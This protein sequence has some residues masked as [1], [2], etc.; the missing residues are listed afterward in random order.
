MIERLLKHDRAVTA[1]ALVVLCCLAWAW[2]LTGAGL[3][4]STGEMM[5]AALFPHQDATMR[6]PGMEMP[7]GQGWSLARSAIVVAMWWT[8]MIAMMIPGAA[9]T[10]LLYARVHGHAAG[11]AAPRRGLAPTGAFVAGYLLIWLAFSAAAAGAQWLLERQGVLSTETLSSN[12]RFLSAATLILAGLYQLS[13]LKQACLSHCRA[14]GSFLARHWRPGVA[15]AVRLGALHGAF[16]LGC[17]WMLM[18]LLF[19]GGVMNLVWIAAL[20]LLVVLEKIVGGGARTSFAA[21]LALIGWGTA[22]L[23]LG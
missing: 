19:V 11:Q 13:P 17:C 14:P 1:A 8:M 2:L 4:M 5:R 22:T 12:S 16:C 10:I 23:L 20:A 9:P 21:G 6:M 15:G 7:D 3:G 18:L